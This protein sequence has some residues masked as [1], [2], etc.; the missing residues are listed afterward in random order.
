MNYTNN[1]TPN[2]INLKNRRS[3]IAILFSALGIALPISLFATSCAATT[4]P[5]GITGSEYTIKYDNQK[6]VIVS[7]GGGIKEYKVG[8]K[9]ITVPYKDGVVPSQFENQ[10]IAPFNNRIPDGEYT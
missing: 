4:Y 7:R 6:A 5:Y 2:K 8:N 3:K 10:M 1:K 9:D